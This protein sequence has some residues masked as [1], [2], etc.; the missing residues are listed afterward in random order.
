M[1]RR[2]EWKTLLV[3]AENAGWSYRPCKHGLCIY[4]PTEGARPIILGGTPSDHRSF[5]NTRAAFRRAGLRDI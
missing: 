4:P 3:A 5:M 1:A 2:N